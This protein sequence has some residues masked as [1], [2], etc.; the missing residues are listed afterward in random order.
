MNN[1]SVVQQGDTVI[2]RRAYG[3]DGV[4][5]F[6]DVNGEW[7]KLWEG[8]VIPKECFHRIVSQDE[9]NLASRVHLLQ[10]RIDALEPKWDRLFHDLIEGFEK[11]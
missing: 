1:I 7:W 11:K 6:L 9:D 2:V 8:A 5:E 3:T 10:R 4:S